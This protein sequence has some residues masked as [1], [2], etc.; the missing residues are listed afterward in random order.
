MRANATGKK[1]YV[2]GCTIGLLAWLYERVPSI[3]SPTSLS[4]FPRFFR[5][6]SSKTGREESK[7]QKALSELTA[8]KVV[9]FIPKSEESKLINLP[10]TCLD[11]CTNS[12]FNGA[13]VL[14][15]ARDV[16]IIILKK[17]IEELEAILQARDQEIIILKKK[18][19]ELEAILQARD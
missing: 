9:L 13:E 18:I 10:A 12:G 3:G 17:K 7:F 14:L 6:D 5:W 15:E 2:N 8:E 19:E 16:E 1:T 4:R 11:D